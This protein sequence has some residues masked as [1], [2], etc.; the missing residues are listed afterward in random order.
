L[1][2]KGGQGV[3][4]GKYQNSTINRIPEHKVDR[5]IVSEREI[6][7]FWKWHSPELTGLKT[8]EDGSP[9]TVIF[10]GTLNDDH[11]ADFRDAVLAT[12]QGLLIGDVELHIDSGGWWAHRH[13]RDP[14]YNR[15][16][17]HVVARSGSRPAC[18]QNGRTVP[19]LSLGEYL[20]SGHT[21]SGPLFPDVSSR[22]PCFHQRGE[23]PAAGTILDEAGDARFQER[24]KG[25][26]TRLSCSTPEDVLYGSVMEALGYHRNRES[27]RRLADAVAVSELRRVIATSIPDNEYRVAC[28]GVL[29]GTAGLLPSQ[30]ELRHGGSGTDELVSLLENAWYHY[31]GRALCTERDWHFSRVRPGNYPV[32]R[33]A[34]A[35][36]LL[37]RFRPEGL[38][39][40]IFHIVEQAGCR[41]PGYLIKELTVPA[42]GYWRDYLDFG[43]P[44]ASPGPALCG[45]GRA[46]DLAVNAVLP[47]A[48]AY[49][50]GNIGKTARDL[51]RTFPGLPDNA[52]L[53]NMKRLLGI[54][55]SRIITARRQQG[56]L[57]VH[58][59]WCSSGD[60]RECPFGR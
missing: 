2:R 7:S 22:L 33:I 4:L 11:G 47:F 15:V 58:H 60:C 45:S 31:G 3:R 39:R 13:D 38:V 21:R 16:V 9:V 41:G 57:R 36:Y 17:L 6:A 44:S 56:L 19:T 34:A 5:R 29:L 32:R 14:A 35:G 46:A 42:V 50:P 51:Y 49:H 28:L 10:P 54:T 55:D 40:S 43:R 26:R 1:V 8:E 23:H 20:D 48:A 27:M 18:L 30:R 24:I 12:R 52:V 53:A 25:F 37:H 59:T